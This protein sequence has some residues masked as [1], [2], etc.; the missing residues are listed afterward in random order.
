MPK[1][2]VTH[3]VLCEVNTIRTIEAHNHDDLL[4]KLTT[5]EIMTSTCWDEPY[6]CDYEIMNDIEIRNVVIKKI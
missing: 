2:H 4:N 5:I 3:T 1:Y 6:P